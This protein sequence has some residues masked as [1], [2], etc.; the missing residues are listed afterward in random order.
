MRIALKIIATV[1]FVIS[2]LGSSLAVIALFSE[3]NSQG[4]TNA[5][6]LGGCMISLLLCGAVWLLADIAESVAGRHL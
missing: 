1:I 6:V 4:A 5:A 3:P 2:A